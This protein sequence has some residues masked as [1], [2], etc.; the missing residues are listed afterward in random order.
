M[1]TKSKIT[2]SGNIFEL[3]RFKE[4]VWHGELPQSKKANNHS[5]KKSKT[6]ER[7]AKSFYRAKGTLKRLIDANIDQ[8]QEESEGKLRPRFFTFTFAENLTNIKIAN[9]EFTKFIKKFNRALEHK[10]N[11]LKYVAVIEFQKRG[12]VHYHALF[13]NLPHI[14]NIY[15]RITELWGNGWV[16]QGRIDRVRNLSSYICK[17]MTKDADDNRLYG[18]KCYFASTNLKKPRTI[19]NDGIVEFVSDFM[20]ES[21]KPYERI[22]PNVSCGE[23]DYKRYD[24]TE[25]QELKKDLL[26]FIK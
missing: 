23:I 21:I 17:Y 13:F 11:F 25:E 1:F 20:P 12:A 5:G 8:S 22:I 15:D 9:A 3:Y 2:I 6:G 4:K 7:S 24:L 26:A 18:Q 14:K 16:I 10:D 19:Y